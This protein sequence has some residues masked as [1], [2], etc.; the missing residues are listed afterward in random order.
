MIWNKNRTI[1]L[2]YLNSLSKNTMAEILG[3]EFVEIGEDYLVARM[4]VDSRTKQP[5]GLLHGGASMAL[6]ETVGSVAGALMLDPT[7]QYLVGL[8]ING[9]HLR[10]ARDGFVY[11]TAR[12]FHCGKTTH[13]WE[14]KITNE[15][16][17]LVCISRITLAVLKK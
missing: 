3:I 13:V 2:E 6:S 5:L 16:G 4:P 10:S 12:P 14:V 1:S 15:N 7:D 11:G 17:E 8:E 9:N